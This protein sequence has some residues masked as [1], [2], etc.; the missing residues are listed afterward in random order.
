MTL[1]RSR[2]LPVALVALGTLLRVLDAWFRQ[3]V[4]GVVAAP[5]EMWSVQLAAGSWSDLVRLTAEDTHPPFYYVLLK[6][7]FV[8]APDTQIS[9]RLMSVAFSAA[10]MAYLYLL[11]RRLFGET[12]ALLAVASAALA[13]YQV[14]W[15]HLA[16]MHAVLPLFALMIV[17][18]TLAFLA[19]GRRRDWALA[20]GGWI[21]AV[22]TSYMALP[23]G[24]VWGVFV[25]MRTEAPWRRRAAILPTGLIGLA[26]LVPWLAVLARQAQEG[27]INRAH[28]QHQVSPFLLYYHS[29]FGDMQPWASPQF[30]MLF[31]LGLLAFACVAVAG[32]R[33]VGR[34]W[35]I[36]AL[37]LLAPTVPIVLHRAMGWTMAERHL[38]FAVPFFMAY[39]GAALE[40]AG[41]AVLERM[42]RVSRPGPRESH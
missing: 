41:R 3:D 1:S 23:F 5:D 33:R 42:R 30:G 32:V 22:Q 8:A 34:Q 2:L 4:P 9:A 10:A 31:L 26:T 39:W 35:S 19:D 11:A 14:Y 38:L 15:G 7:W 6:L 24:L 13:P 20:A 27:P 21:L 16:R 29:M 40:Q 37:L 17:E 36:W 25:L 18:H 12:A 28:F